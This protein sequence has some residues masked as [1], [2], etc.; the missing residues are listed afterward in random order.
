[1]ILITK[2]ELIQ[3][4]DEKGYRSEI[5]EKVYRLLEF[6]GRLYGYTFFERSIGFERGYSHQFILF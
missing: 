2:N 4:A 6:I 3:I 5:L 1:M